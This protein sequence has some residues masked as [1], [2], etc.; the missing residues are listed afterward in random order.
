MRTWP[1]R[2]VCGLHNSISRFRTWPACIVHGLHLLDDRHC[3]RRHWSRSSRQHADVHAVQKS[4]ECETP[5]MHNNI[6]IYFPSSILNVSASRG[7]FVLIFITFMVRTN[8]TYLLVVQI[9]TLSLVSHVYKYFQAFSYF[10][11]FYSFF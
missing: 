4:K 1:G 10:F 3:T 7:S 8:L 2:I 11:N 9:C 5:F 6:F